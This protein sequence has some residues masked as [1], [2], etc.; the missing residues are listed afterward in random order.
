MAA[1]SK[2]QAKIKKDLEKQGWTVIRLITATC[3]V[4]QSGI[5]D[6]LAI[7]HNDNGTNDIR[8]I[9]VKAKKGIVS[10]IQKYVMS[11]LEKLG[12]EVE[13]NREP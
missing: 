5:P 11:E 10:P 12:F 4:S 2:Y 1:E 8:F 3:S 7:R 13:L 9:E 6:L